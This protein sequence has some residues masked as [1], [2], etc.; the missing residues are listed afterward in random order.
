MLTVCAIVSLTV[1]VYVFV[2]ENI[3]MGVAVRPS[4]CVVVSERVCLCTYP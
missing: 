3:A 1:Q 2:M 4:V